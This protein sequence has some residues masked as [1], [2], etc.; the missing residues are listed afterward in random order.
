MTGEQQAA[1]LVDAEEAT[2]SIVGMLQ[3]VEASR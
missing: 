1:D 3:E 2:N